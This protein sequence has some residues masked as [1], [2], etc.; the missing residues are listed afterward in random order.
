[1]AEN[2]IAEI[3]ALFHPQRIAAFGVSATAGK[4]GNLLLQSFIDLGFEGEL[5]PIHPTASE[6]MGLPAYP[7]L[8]AYGNSIDLAII[9]VHP[10]KVFDAI[11]ECVEKEAKGII[12][13]SSGFSERGTEGKKLEEEIVEYARNRGTRIIG[14][15][16][17]GLYSPASRISFFP[18]LP[19][20]TS[21]EV[22]FISQSGSLSVNLAFDAALKGIYFSKMISVGN[23]ADL[24][25]TDF[26]E[27]LGQD[28]QTK[29]IT[30]YVEGI[31]DGQRFLKVARE[32]SKKKPIIMW[33][34][35][36]TAGGKKGCTFP[37]GINWGRFS[38]L[39]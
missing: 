8:E 21:G 29:I 34:V 25:L 18:G 20:E 33:K 6:I 27:Y 4:L 15:N 19:S 23:G 35:G 37:Y 28:S 30:C 11:K 3:E 7:S 36:E 39:A 14:P 12:V 31:K 22:G 38:S 17:M 13:F 26:L 32:V 1:M 9:S 24:N 10:S 5:I 2:V 16:C